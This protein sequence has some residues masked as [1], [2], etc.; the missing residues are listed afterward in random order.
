VQYQLVA[1]ELDVS[2]DRVTLI[3]CDT[4]LAPDQG[5]T[6]GS[7]SSTTEFGPSGL[8]Q[9]LATARAAPFQMASQQLNVSMDQLTVADGVISM[10]TDPS[11]QMSYGQL[12]GGQQFKL[13]VDSR[14]TTKDPAKYTIL[15]ASVQRFD[16]PARPRDSINTCS[17]FASPVCCTARVVGRPPWAPMSSVS[18]RRQSRI[19]RVTSRLSSKD[20]VGVVADKEWQAFGLWPHWTSPGPTAI[21]CPISRTSTTTSRQQPS[22]DA[23]TVLASD[24]DAKLKQSAS[25]VSAT[26]LYSYQMHGSI[27]SSC[28]VADV[29]G[30]GAAAGDDLVAHPRR[31]SA[32]RQCGDGPRNSQPECARDLRG[33]VGLLRVERRGYGILRRGAA[34]AGRW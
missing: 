33:R 20:F 5:V 28:S 24:V 16:I 9:A 18:M 13:A 25:V 22:R 26:Y 12:I 1:E 19:F 6:S 27:G 8:R 30:T 7:Q 29:K 34:V 4:A 23:Y 31:L 2:I 11:Q 14:A 21:R 17:T 3:A 32:A 15:G 10:K